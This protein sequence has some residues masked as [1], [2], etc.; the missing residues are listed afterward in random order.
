MAEETDLSL[1]VSETPKIGYVTSGPIL[2][3]GPQSAHQLTRG[4]D[5]GPKLYA[6]WDSYSLESKSLFRKCVCS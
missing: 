5:S 3:N 2:S 1:A 4:A 6:D